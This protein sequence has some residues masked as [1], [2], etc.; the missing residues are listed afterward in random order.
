M[1]IGTFEENLKKLVLYLQAEILWVPSF[2][3]SGFGFSFIEWAL[4][5]KTA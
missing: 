5:L 4:D 2:W 1:I 3:E